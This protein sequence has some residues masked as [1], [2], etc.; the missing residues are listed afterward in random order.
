MV[1]FILVS[2]GLLITGCS[3][4]CHKRLWDS[5]FKALPDDQIEARNLQQRRAKRTMCDCNLEARAMQDM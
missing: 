4:I 1:S 3:P 2:Q 5:E